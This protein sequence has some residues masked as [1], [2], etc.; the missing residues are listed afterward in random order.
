MY[1][2][3]VVCLRMRQAWQIGAPSL[4]QYFVNLPSACCTS[5]RNL[6]GRDAALCRRDS[7]TTGNPKKRRKKSWRAF[8]PPLLLVC[9]SLLGS[10]F[11]D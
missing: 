1:S 5:G 3:A 4:E 2:R 6:D 7:C 8:R 11:G 10:S 9:R